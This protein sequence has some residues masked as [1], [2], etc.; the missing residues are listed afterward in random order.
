MKTFKLLSVF[1]FLL[2]SITLSAQNFKVGHPGEVSFK[3]EQDYVDFHDEVLQYIHWLENRSLKH[4][5]RAKANAIFFI[6]LE[7][8]SSVT[9]TLNSFVVDYSKKNEDF[10]LLFMAGW[11]KKSLEDPESK[12]SAYEGSLAGL[13]AILDFYVKG[14]EFGVKK[15]KKM[16]KLMKKRTAGELEAFV[17]ELMGKK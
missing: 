16:E 3:S 1:S 9:V 15:D 12:L 7:G 8:T 2:L 17:K 13:N 5:D 4:P 6:W 14:K 10:L 11:V